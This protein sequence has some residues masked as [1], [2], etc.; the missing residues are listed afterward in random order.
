MTEVRVLQVGRRIDI[1]LSLFLLQ[2]ISLL[3]SWGRDLRMQTR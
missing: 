2:A 3:L 1:A